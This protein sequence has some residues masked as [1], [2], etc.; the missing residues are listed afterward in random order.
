ME[1]EVAWS[2]YNEESVKEVFDFAEDY[3][4]FISKCKTE[5]ECVKGSHCYG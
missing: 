5:R 2:K 1:R 3:R 4:Q